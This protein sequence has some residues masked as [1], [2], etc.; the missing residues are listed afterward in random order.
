MYILCFSSNLLLRHERHNMFPSIHRKLCLGLLLPLL[1]SI[2][3]SIMSFKNVSLCFIVLF[4]LVHFQSFFFLKYL[5]LAVFWV[6]LNLFSSPC[7]LFSPFL[8]PTSLFI[9]FQ[10]LCVIVH[11]SDYFIFCSISNELQ[12]MFNRIRYIK[13]PVSNNRLRISPIEPTFRKELPTRVWPAFS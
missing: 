2:F 6:L 10:S 9:W 8:H 13:I 1:P 7:Y 4:C 5:F 12:E 3:P 11:D